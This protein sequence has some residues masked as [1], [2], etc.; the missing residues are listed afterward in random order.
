MTGIASPDDWQGAG[1]FACAGPVVFNTPVAVYGNK[2]STAGGFVKAVQHL[3][4]TE[5]RKN[6]L[7]GRIKAQEPFLNKLECRR[8]GHCLRHRDTGTAS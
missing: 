5:F 3:Q 2:R 6:R 1:N 4:L 8:S 7:D